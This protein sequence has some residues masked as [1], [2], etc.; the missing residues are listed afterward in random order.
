MRSVTLDLLD[1]QLL[2]AFQLDGRAAFSAI[3]EVLGVSDRTVARRYDRLRSSGAVRVAGVPDSRLTGRADWLVRLSALPFSAAP[4][5]RALARRTDTARVT[6]A[7][8]GTEIVC[9]FRVA[10][11][12]PAPLADLG[13]LP[14]ITG[15][16]AQRLLRPAMNGR[17][18]G[19]TSA[20]DEDQIA[21]LQ[22]SAAADPVPPAGPLAEADGAAVPLTRL[23]RSLLPALAADGRA[24]YP[25]PARRSGW[26]ESAVRRRL[27][28]LRRAAVVTFDVEVDAGL[29]GFSAQCLLWLTVTP[30]RLGDVARTLAQ[31]PEAAFVST[32]TGPDNLFAIVVCRDTGALDTYLTD[33]LGALDGVDRVETALVTAYTR[34]AARVERG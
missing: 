24:T 30:A 12:G 16:R 8:S 11:G 19:R 18:R 21:A 7:S 26:S 13:R 23:D 31:D 5:A 22:P 25:A 27:S 17:W 15:V 32:T 10:A 6:L 2:H 34:R 3:A 33:R 20:L 14:Q 4:L 29:L 9:V 1:R 28:E